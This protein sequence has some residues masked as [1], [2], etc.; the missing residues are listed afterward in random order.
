MSSSSLIAA[1][2][3]SPAFGN[4]HVDAGDGAH[5]ADGRAQ[6]RVLC[7][8]SRGGI[9]ANSKNAISV[10]DASTPPQVGEVEKQ[11]EK[12]VNVVVNTQAL[13]VDERPVFFAKLL[14]HVS[15]GGPRRETALAPY[16]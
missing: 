7:L 6:I 16:R 8:R 1:A 9:T 12:G 15:S 4:R 10:G 2:C 13:N 5:R 14:P 11:L 3:S